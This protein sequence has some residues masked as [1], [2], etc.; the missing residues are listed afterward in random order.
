MVD[1][2]E[3]MSTFASDILAQKYANENDDGSLETW[4]DIAHR[5]A[6][7]VVGPY[8]PDRVAE[9]EQII[10]DRKFLPGGRYLY[11]SGK[12][13]KAVNN[14]MLLEV[15]DSR[16]GWADVA[17]RATSALMTGAGIGIVYSKLRGEGAYIKGL[18][19]TS[20]G[21]ISVMKMVNEIGR[22]VMQGGARRSAIWAGLHWN[23]PDIFTFIHAK[24]W[25]DEVKRLKNQDFNFPADLDMTNISII[26][27]DEFFNAYH[28]NNHDD[29]ELAV[30]VYNKATLQMVSTGEPGF[31][32]DV[33][34]N[35][36]E[37]LRN[38]CTEIVSKD[39]NDV[40][41]LGSINV[42]QIGS[43]EELEYISEVATLF[44]LCGTFYADLPYDEVYEVRKKNRRLGLGLM[45][46]YEWL[47]MR[48]KQYGPDEELAQWLSVWQESSDKAAQHYAEVFDVVTPVAVR[49]IAPNGTIAIIGET[50]GGIEPVF[51][52]AFK[53]RYLKGTQWHAQY[54][55]DAT[56]RRL[57][58]QGVDAAK[59]EDAYDLANDVMR[60]VDFQVFVQQYVDNAISSTVNLPAWGSEHNNEE[61]LKEFR[62]NAIY[63]LPYL[64]GLTVY[65]DGA[66]GGQP[67]TPANLDEA[68]QKEGVEFEEYGS[69]HGCR[70]GVC[71]V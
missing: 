38:A 34:E 17:R 25:S 31:S 26:L 48:G 29:H 33:A 24:D 67:L 5:V 35:S 22:N 66:R 43:I 62:E 40:C 10:R 71:G 30:N 70:D 6:S 32:I 54:V 9:V 2:A 47:L 4:E 63:R 57:V 15:E 59:I 58:D 13:L 21:P 46:L 14:C 3:K 28:N 20:T 44:L 7:E 18:G 12:P 68:L 39:D 50:T 1:T 61:T 41:N 8:A 42:S 27:D 60:R 65:P 23:H 56:A 64:R 49:A 11:A 51:C 69:E 37:H 16:E 36:G 55:V 19:G 52:S 45:G 53:R